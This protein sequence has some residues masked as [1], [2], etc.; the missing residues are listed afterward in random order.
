[1]EFTDSQVF[2]GYVYPSVVLYGHI[3]GDENEG[4]KIAINYNTYEVEH[5][6]G[7]KWLIHQE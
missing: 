4:I 1:M 5:V 3:Q 6:G 7:P 2:A